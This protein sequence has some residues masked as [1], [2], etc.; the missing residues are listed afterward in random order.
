MRLIPPRAQIVLFP[1][2]FK[3]RD[4]KI[5]VFLFVV[6]VVVN[7]KGGDVGAARFARSN[8]FNVLDGEIAHAVGFDLAFSLV[9][10]NDIF[11]VEGF[12]D[13]FLFGAEKSDEVFFGDEVFHSVMFLLRVKDKRERREVKLFL[14]RRKKRQTSPREKTECRQLYG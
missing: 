2:Q 9:E 13:C 1:G 3:A 5:S 7:D 11:A 10:V 4:V 6:V 8:V 14:T 12:N